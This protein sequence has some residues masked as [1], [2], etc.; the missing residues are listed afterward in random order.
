MTTSPRPA[1]YGAEHIVVPVWEEQG[2]L[3]LH[4]VVG[5]VCETADFLGR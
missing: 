2:P 5:P 4:T 3:A 1:L